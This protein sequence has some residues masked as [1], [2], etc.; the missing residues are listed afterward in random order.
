MDDVK[1]A[2]GDLVLE[3][4][5][6]GQGPLLLVPEARASQQQG[7]KQADGAEDRL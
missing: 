4:S 2:T 7:H 5:V 1:V 6:P 3:G